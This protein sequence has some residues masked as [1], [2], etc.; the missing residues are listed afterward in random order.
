MYTPYMP[1]N[2]KVR[3]DALAASNYYAGGYAA[4]HAGARCTQN[5]F[6]KS[7]VA[8]LNW[9]AGWIEADIDSKG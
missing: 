1:T 8:F 7:T 3:K 2:A 5:P 9:R 4:F 6:K